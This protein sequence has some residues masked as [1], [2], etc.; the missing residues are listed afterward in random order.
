MFWNEKP[1]GWP[2]RIVGVKALLVF[3]E[4]VDLHITM[5]GV[6]FVIDSPGNNILDV[7]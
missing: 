3:I 6:T 1:E 4:G 2:V 5:G 7:G